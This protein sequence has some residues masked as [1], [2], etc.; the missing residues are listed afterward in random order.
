MQQHL[1][2]C[3]EPSILKWSKHVNFVFI[4][5]QK[6]VDFG[7]KI[8]FN[9]TD[10]FF[11]KKIHRWMYLLRMQYDTRFLQF[12]DTVDSSIAH[13]TIFV[14]KRKAQMNRRVFSKKGIFCM[15]TIVIFLFLESAKLAIVQLINLLQTYNMGKG[16]GLCCEMCLAREW[17]I[18]MQW[19]I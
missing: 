2:V 4:N 11:S 19:F 18:S 13:S 10:V 16:K 12:M 17:E 9:E 15:V 14:S 6:E 8:R 1:K 7:D 5:A 3:G